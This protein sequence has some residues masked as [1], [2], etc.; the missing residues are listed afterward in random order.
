MSPHEVERDTDYR[1]GTV[2]KLERC[3]IQC[4]QAAQRRE[5]L[6]AG[7]LKTN[8]SVVQLRQTTDDE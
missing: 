5:H 8:Q 3:R 2:R 7:V 4:K 6:M 1:I